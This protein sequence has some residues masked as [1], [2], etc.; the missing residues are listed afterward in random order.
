[1]LFKARSQ[2][3]GTSTGTCVGET[4]HRLGKGPRS[5]RHCPDMLMEKV[6]LKENY[7]A[8]DSLLMAL[9]SSTWEPEE[10]KLGMVGETDQLSVDL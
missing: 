5:L 10:L 2:A 6:H 7:M 1:M 4:V 9:G 8:S 3:G